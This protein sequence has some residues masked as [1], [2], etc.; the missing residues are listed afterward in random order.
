MSGSGISNF[1][2]EK[3]AKEFSSGLSQEFTGVFSKDQLKPFRDNQCAII[4][5]ENAQDS[6]GRELPG[7]HWVSAGI[8]QG[9]SWYFDSFGLGIP[10]E[11][12]KALKEPIVHSKL[13]VQAMD[14]D[15]CGHFA[16]GACVAVCSVSNSPQVS[17]KEFENQFR[18]NIDLNKNDRQIEQYLEFHK[19]HKSYGGMAYNMSLSYK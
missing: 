17:L 14:S 9:Q 11:I 4:N 10:I 8:H 6:K 5:I 1:D 2:L 18:G 7:T 12:E 16:L 19:R 13:D 3:E 15:E